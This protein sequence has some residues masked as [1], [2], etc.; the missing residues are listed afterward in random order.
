MKN[1]NNTQ[2]TNFNNENSKNQSQSGWGNNSYNQNSSNYYANSSYNTNDNNS[3]KSSF[4]FLDGKLKVYM[5]RNIPR[6]KH[7]SPEKYRESSDPSRAELVYSKEKNPVSSIML[8]L[9]GL[10]FLLLFYT[11]VFGIISNS[12]SDDLLVQICAFF[13]FSMGVCLFW[14]ALV[15]PIIKKARCT[16]KVI[17]KVADVIVRKNSKG[18]ISETPIYK[19]YYED[20]IYIIESDTSSI[21]GTHKGKAVP[22][23]GE[24]VE[25][26]INEKKPDDYYIESK[27]NDFLKL[28]FAVIIIVTSFAMLI[29][30]L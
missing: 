7:F 22:A 27:S 2:N 4:T 24:Y 15:T 1:F 30:F 8:I 28:L 12:I 18:D 6:K 13:F 26:L 21:I 20:K 19:F 11:L 14:D 29:I 25:M 23:K 16:Y 17:A 3:D 9:M 5:G 10:F